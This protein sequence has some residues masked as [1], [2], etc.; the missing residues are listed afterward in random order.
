MSNVL[1]VCL[2]GCATGYLVV[3]LLL[4]DL[5]MDMSIDAKDYRRYE[6]ESSEEDKCPSKPKKAFTRFIRVFGN[7]HKYR[8]LFHQFSYLLYHPIRC[9]FL[10]LRKN[11]KQPGCKAKCFVGCA[12]SGVK[13]EVVVVIEFLNGVPVR[14]APF[15]AA[16]FQRTMWI[17]DRNTLC[18][19][20]VTNQITHALQDVNGLQASL[21]PAPSLK[22]WMLNREKEMQ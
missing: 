2:W 11:S 19:A 12:Y 4:L 15:K 5:T 3:L 13:G 16:G 18:V 22:T 8:C 17:W 7:H 20:I 1:T 9:F 10:L 14:W 21:M 6:K